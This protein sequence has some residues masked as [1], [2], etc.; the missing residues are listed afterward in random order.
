MIITV[1]LRDSK[2]SRKQLDELIHLFSSEYEF[3][4]TY[5]QTIGDRQLDVSLRNMDKTDFFTRDIDAIQLAGKVRI[6]LHSAKDLPEP[7]PKGL[8]MVA[9]TKGQ[10]PSDSLVFREGENLETLP[11][12]ALVG[13]SSPRRDKIVQTLRPDLLCVE[14]RGTIEKRLEKLFQGEIDALVVAEAALIRLELTYVNRISLPGPV[15]PLQGQLAVLAREGDHEMAK[16]FASLDSRRHNPGKKM[17]ETTLYLGLDPSN[18]KTENTLIHCPIIQIFP[19]DFNLPQIQYVFDDIPKYTHFIF[20]SKVG[21][22]VF[23]D[24]LAHYQYGI[25]ILEGKE[26]I[27]IG[28]STAKAA[29]ARGAHVTQV[30]KEETQEGI[31]RMLAVQNLDHAF[32]FLPCSA[33]SRPDLAH[34]LMIKRIRHQ[35]CKL[36]DTRAVELKNRPALEEIDEIV[37][38]SPSTVDAFKKIFGEI[39]K[40]KKLIPIGPITQS[41]LNSVFTF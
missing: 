7:L 5:L 15:A 1:G 17:A 41:K 29:R 39:P 26:I 9:L 3:Q 30:A 40:N 2:L 16:L 35:L 22:N 25:D 31:I 10:D 38:T 27:A 23:F 34:F 21:V 4:P 24:C 19:R 14:V 28:E 13:S 33:L 20:T 37:F 12:G 18:F 32:V 6:S 11:S 8:M 36:Y